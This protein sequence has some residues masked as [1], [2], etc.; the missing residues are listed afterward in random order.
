M[1]V[2]AAALAAFGHE[3]ENAADAILIAGVPVLHGGVFDVRIIERDEL[4]ITSPKA[5][6][7]QGGCGTCTVLMNGETIR[8]CITFAVQAD[9]AELTTVESLANGA[10]MHPLQEAF[11]EKQG[12][13]CGYCPPAMIMVAHALLTDNPEPTREEIVEAISGNIC[14]C[15]GYAQIVEAIALAAQRMRGANRPTEL[16]R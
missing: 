11:W 9:G 13:Q 2:A 4:D 8:S 3:I 6:C 1:R 5:G 12:L 10:A 16:D 14:R 15:T 7:Q